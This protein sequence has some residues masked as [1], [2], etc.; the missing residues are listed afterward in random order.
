MPRGGRGAHAAS[1]PAGSLAASGQAELL[2]SSEPVRAIDELVTAVARTDAKVLITGESGAGKEVV[3]RLIH[4]RSARSRMPFAAINCAGVSESLL[5]SEMFGH[6][7]GSFTGADRDRA[8]LFEACNGGTLFLD[9]IGEMSLRMQALLLR[10]LESGEIQR[11]GADRQQTR[12]DVRI[13]AATNRDLAQRI[14]EGTFRLDLYYRL[15]VVHVHVPPLRERRED[16]PVLLN[17]F[18][19]TYAAK[20]GVPAAVILPDTIEVL[21]AYSW[22]G[23]VRELRNLAERLVVRSGSGEP[24]GP[25]LLP[26]EIRRQPVDER[27]TQQSAASTQVIA[28]ILD[29]M[30]TGGESFW[31]AVHTPFMTRDLTR[32]EVRAVVAQGLELTR[33]SYKQVLA[34]FNLPPNDYKPFLSFL[35][36]HDCHMPFQSFRAGLGATTTSRDSVPSRDTLPTSTPPLPDRR[37]ID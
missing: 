34:K 8:G 6:V 37:D 31:S 2:G 12:I 15:N 22:P 17:D 7:R 13:L 20:E 9:E 4:R 21:Q 19:Q 25:C 24:V 23:N 27:T 16:I 28:G 26:P 29:R 35:R 30:I 11:V 3:A 10:F 36:K 33:G 1:S 32:R 18:L 14:K 5:E